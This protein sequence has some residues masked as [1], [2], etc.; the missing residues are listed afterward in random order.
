MSFVAPSSLG[1][2]ASAYPLSPTMLQHS[3]TDHPL[4]SFEALA[5]ASIDL[6]PQFVE[7]RIGNAPNGGEFAMDRSDDADVATVIR[8][9]QT[10]GCL[11]YTSPS[12]RDS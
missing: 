2:F 4:L 11:L 8:S 1:P 3:L 9:I 7:R 6:P 12:P 5:K 10:S